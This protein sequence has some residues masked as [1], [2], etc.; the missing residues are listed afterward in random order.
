LASEAGRV[1]DDNGPGIPPE[2]REKVFAAFYRLERS[3]NRE[4]GGVGLGLSVAREHGG[5]IIL[6]AFKGAGLRVRMQ[7][8]I[9]AKMF[10][11]NASAKDEVAAAPI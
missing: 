10:T 9:L 4:T 1:I 5:D 11:G 2:E 3:R 6:T 7:L 8:P